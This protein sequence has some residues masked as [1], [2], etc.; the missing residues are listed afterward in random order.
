MLG[1]PVDL[2]QTLIT[3]LGYKVQ[4]PVLGSE[5]LLD[6]GI[7]HGLAKPRTGTMG[8]MAGDVVGGL[9]DP[10]PSTEMALAAKLPGL[11]AKGD[12]M[13]GLLGGMTAFHGSPHKFTPTPK[14]LLGEFDHSKMGSGEGA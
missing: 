13:G 11:M 3:P 5:W 6:K 8:E 12:I 9:L 4:K 1:A 10:S 14:N 7:K 2:M